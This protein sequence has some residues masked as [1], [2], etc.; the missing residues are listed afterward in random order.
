MVETSGEQLSQLARKLFDQAAFRWY[1]AVC[2][3][4]LVASLGAAVALTSIDPQVASLIAVLILV[5]TGGAYL[6]RLSGE[7]AHDLAETMRRQAALSEGLGWSV[8]RGQMTEWR[9]KAGRKLRQ[10]ALAEPREQGYY[11][12]SPDRGPRKLAEMT[13][14][15]EFWTRQLFISLRTILGS[16]LVIAAV[17]TTLVLLVVLSQP[18]LSSIGQ[19]LA[20]LVFYLLLIVIDLDLIG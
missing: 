13:L 19:V 7:S 2:L 8:E 3:Q 6:V 12:A 11:T 4:G 17:A 1:L 16:A 9:R 18:T 20:R 14:E 15:S 5:L 10:R